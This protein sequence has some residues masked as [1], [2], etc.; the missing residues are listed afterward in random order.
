M[1]INVV[2]SDF[3]QFIKNPA[4]SYFDRLSLGK[5]FKVFFI[6]MGFN[7][8]IQ[9]L[10]AFQ[11]NQLNQTL[12]GPENTHKLLEFALNTPS[13]LLFFTT[14]ITAPVLEELGFRLSLVFKPAFLSLSILALSP[15][16]LK[17]IVVPDSMPYL[18]I[19]IASI[20]SLA[21]LFIFKIPSLRRSTAQ[22]WNQ[23]LRWIV[24]GFVAFFGLLHISNFG[25]LSPKILLYSPLITLPQ[26]LSGFVLSYL[27]LR[28]GF[29]WSLLY[30]FLWNAS[31]ISL[32]I[33]AKSMGAL[34]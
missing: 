19:L 10:M 26:I 7:A 11:I 6:I 21:V 25:S 33:L 32:V 18:K 3:W 1:T 15:F 5:T 13:I 27:R 28:F 30:H 22:F 34:I 23:H 12:M 24:Y 31:A 2:F 17:N 14:A 4:T 29:Q 9:L 8:L 16:V 20:L